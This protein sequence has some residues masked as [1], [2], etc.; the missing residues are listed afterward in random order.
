[1]NLNSSERESEL[2]K[3]TIVIPMYNEEK[4]IPKVLDN[5]KDVMSESSW[6]YEIIAVD[7]GSSDKTAEIV[8]QQEEIKLIQHNENRGYGAALKTGI[9]RASGDIIV[10]TDADGTYPNDKI[11]EMLS[12][13]GDYDM[14]VGARIGESV[15]IPLLRKPAKAILAYLANFLA[16]T[17]IPDLNS[18]LR[19]FKKE[20][21]MKYFPILPPGFSFTTTITLAMLSNGYAVK[22]IPINYHEREGKSKIRPIRDTYNFILLIIRTITYFNPLKIFL[23]LSLFLFLIGFISAIYTIIVFHNVTDTQVLL[24]LTSIELGMIGLL[25]DLIVKRGELK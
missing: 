13:I 8:Q 4:G 9:R 18:G 3:V 15:K 14:V 2:A 10:I 23:S 25:A 19:A 1:M 6:D 24:I 21:V 11:P 17:K 20:V 22:Y 5:I 12:Y 16:E 7:D